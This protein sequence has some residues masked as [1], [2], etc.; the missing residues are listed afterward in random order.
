MNIRKRALAGAV[1]V[2]LGSLLLS[3]QTREF[4]PVTD[5]MLQKP[6]AG[7]WLH[8]RG[9]QNAWGYNPP[10]QINRGNVGQ[11]QLA[12]S[13][14]MPQGS[15]GPAPLGHDGVIYIP[16]PRCRVQGLDAVTRDL[17]LA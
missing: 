7:E 15:A 14:A 11:L 9:A 10:D 2:T 8:W 16:P 12:W 1:A 3:A 13:W 4:Q 6:A 5:A 17:F